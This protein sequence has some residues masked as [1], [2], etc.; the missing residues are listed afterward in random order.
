MS[1]SKES[2]EP[3]GPVVVPP[4]PAAGGADSRRFTPLRSYVNPARARGEDAM[5]AEGTAPPCSRLTPL[6]RLRS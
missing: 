2:P 3:I 5:R 4:V 1:Q 6:A